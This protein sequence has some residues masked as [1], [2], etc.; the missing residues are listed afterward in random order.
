MIITVYE[1]SPHVINN[2]LSAIEAMRLALGPGVIMT[3]ILQGLHHPARKVREV[4]W[5]IYNTTYMGAAD[6]LV[7]FYPRL[8]SLGEGKNDYRRPA[9]D[10]YV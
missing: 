9:L 3:Y 10:I 1:T 4:Y 7:P 8:D 6:S 2:V 5:R